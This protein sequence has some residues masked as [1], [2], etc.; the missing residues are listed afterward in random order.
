[1]NIKQ[2][3]QSFFMYIALFMV[4]LL[5]WAVFGTIFL[6]SA[7]SM[8]GRPPLVKPYPTQH[9]NTD[10]VRDIKPSE[11]E[12]LAELKDPALDAH[13]LR[14]QRALKRQPIKNSIRTPR[15]DD[16]KSVHEYCNNVSIPTES[17]RKTLSDASLWGQ[18]EYWATP[19]EFIAKGKGDCEDFAI[20]KYYAFRSLGF[21][22]NQLNIWSGQHVGTRIGHAV[23]AVQL[24]GQEYVLDNL[25]E[26]IFKAKDYMNRRFK[27]KYRTN[28]NGWS[29]F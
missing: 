5:L 28:E 24:D 9:G 20:C 1:M 16:L 3:V 23:L 17:N 29:F 18:S 11:A 10:W 2:V 12:E 14:W 13:W 22:P 21:Q 8:S 27:P 26:K 15:L 25:Y 7:H 19:K 4:A 6:E